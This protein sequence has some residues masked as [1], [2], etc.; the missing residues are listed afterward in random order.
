MVGLGPGAERRLGVVLGAMLGEPEPIARDVAAFFRDYLARAPL[1][2]AVGLR[3]MVWALLWLPIV[4][5]GRPVPASA[6]SPALRARYLERWAGARSYL[7][8]E[9]FFLVKT[10]ALFG[11]GAHPV[12]RARFGMPDVAVSHGPEGAVSRGLEGSEGA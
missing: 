8:R 9:G 11:W 10:V 1:L 12:V 7:V 4:F 5:V 2:A 6:L 3:F